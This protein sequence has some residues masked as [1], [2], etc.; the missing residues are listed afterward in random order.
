MN[1]VGMVI[2]MSHSA[3]RS[4]LEAIDHS[5]Q[6]VIISTPIPVTSSGANKSDKVIDAIAANEG[7]LGFS[8]YPFT[9]ERPQ[10]T[11]DDFCD[12]VAWTADRMGIDALAWAQTSARPA[13]V[14]WS[15]CAMATA[16]WITAR[17]T[18]TMPA[19][20]TP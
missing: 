8:P 14:C 7:L 6:P 13:K 15:G 3:E 1:R 18:R 11:L 19:G 5:E 12:M 4:T 20:P 17:A 9:E 2:D 10:C 16:R